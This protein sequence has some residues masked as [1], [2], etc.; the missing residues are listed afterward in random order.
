MQLKKQ[1]QKI[2]MVLDGKKI[3]YEIVD[4]S[5]SEEGKQKMRDIVGDPNAL[6]PQICNGETYCGVSV[7][8]V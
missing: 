2:T 5:R 1:Q 3:G 7:I 8:V 4:I 6:P